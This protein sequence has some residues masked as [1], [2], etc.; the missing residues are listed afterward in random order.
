MATPITDLRAQLSREINVPGVETLPDITN[1]QLDGYIADGFWET[2]LYGMLADYTL[3]DGT[4]FATPVTGGV[5]KKAADDDDLPEEYQQLV[6]IVAA[7]RMLRMKILNL[8]INFK[9]DGGPVS[10]EQQASAT[11]LRAILATLQDRLNT[12]QELYSETLQ[13]GAFQYFDS[14]LQRDASMMSNALEYTVIY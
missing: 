3:T 8:A 6:V 10:Y 12:L 4:E 1:S 9:A 14:V 7:L 2:R 13:G 11:T 5:I